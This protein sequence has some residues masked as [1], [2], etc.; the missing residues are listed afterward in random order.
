MNNR[1]LFG[2]AIDPPIPSEALPPISSIVGD[3]RNSL[4]E[5]FQIFIVESVYYSIWQHV[6]S[7]L[8]SEYGGVLVGHPFKT[9][10]N[11]ITFV[12]ITGFIPQPTQ[13]RGIAHFTVGP[14][15]VASTRNVLDKR[16]SGLAIVGWYHS[17]PGHG[18]FLSEQDMTIVRSIYNLDWHI[19]MVLDPVNNKSGVFIGPAGIP[20]QNMI[21]LSKEPDAIEAI[22]LYNQLKHSAG[23]ENVNDPMLRAKISDMVNRST[24]LRHWKKQGIYQE[25]NLQP[26]EIS[27]MH[28]Y[29]TAN[30][31]VPL[32]ARK[33]QSPLG[34]S[35][36][37]ALVFGPALVFAVLSLLAVKWVKVSDLII[38]IGLGVILNLLAG[39]GV[40][41]LFNTS[42]RENTTRTKRTESSFYKFLGTFLLLAVITSVLVLLVISL[43]Y[44]IFRL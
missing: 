33:K 13:N 31:A 25:L 26:H 39:Y 28:S 9:L 1:I 34:T 3:N 40:V 42:S 4:S 22:A 30:P 12:V 7:T 38:I 11:S 8:D 18:V 21:M 23:S 32:P 35:Q 41:L 5:P 14:D 6:N 24:E 20:T 37:M 15:E 43:N 17:H 10:D 36:S 44:S 2:E 16:Y 27:E 19:A 29:Q